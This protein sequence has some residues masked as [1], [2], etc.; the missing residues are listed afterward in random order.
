[1]SLVGAFMLLGIPVA[2]IAGI[3]WARNRLRAALVLSA[4]LIGTAAAG[5]HAT[6]ARRRDGPRAPPDRARADGR[7]RALCAAERGRR[8]ALA[9]ATVSATRRAD[10]LAPPG[11]TAGRSSLASASRTS[12]MAPRVLRHEPAA[13]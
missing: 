13:L 12:G 6:G 8:L 1:M 10:R 7:R 11:V 4:M 2:L 9:A 3:D 5:A